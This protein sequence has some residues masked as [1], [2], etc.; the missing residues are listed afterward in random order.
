MVSYGQMR[1]GIAAEE[2]R[3][4][5]DVS[6]DTHRHVTWLCNSGM[7]NHDDI[8]KMLS[9]DSNISKFGIDMNEWPPLTSAQSPRKRR[10]ATV[11][12]AIPLGTHRGEG[13]LPKATPAP[14]EAAEGEELVVLDWGLRR[15]DETPPPA[16]PRR[17]RTTPPEGRQLRF[18]DV[19]GIIRQQPRVRAV[20]I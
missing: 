12:G 8:R 6:P 13:A 11:A 1:P 20:A 15:P 4:E 3:D 2:L 14:R 10:V 16:Q 19:P 7:L 5:F 18:G 17:A 9:G